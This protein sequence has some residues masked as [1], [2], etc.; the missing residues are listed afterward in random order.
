ML[1]SSILLA[2]S[3]TV[4]ADQEYLK[5][6]DDQVEALKKDVIS[7]NRDLFILE[8]ELLFPAN[9]QTFYFLS[10]EGKAFF[11]LDSVELKI[12]GKTETHYLYTDREIKALVKG[13]VQRLHIG[14]LNKG[15]HE[16]VAVF[17]GTGPEGREYRRGATFTFE[18]GFD[19]KFIELKIIESKQ[20]N[21]PEFE[22][23]EWE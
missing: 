23:K 19:P 5:G 15:E 1:L 22:I 18:K 11:D 8:E 9:T 21:Q 3:S 16:L 13:G 20:K 14:N 10:M 4:F 12:D 2:L 6:I 7:I 17:I